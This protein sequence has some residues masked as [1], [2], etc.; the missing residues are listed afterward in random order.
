MKIKLLFFSIFFYRLE[1]YQ[2]INQKVK[3]WKLNMDKITW[4]GL[5]SHPFLCGHFEINETALYAHRQVAHAPVTFVKCQ[6]H[7]N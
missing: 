7:E 5:W 4:V 1:Y 6:T 2:N 3:H